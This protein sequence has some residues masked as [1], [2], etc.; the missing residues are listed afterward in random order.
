MNAVPRRVAATV[1]LGTLLNPL[2]SSM[3]VVGLVTLQREFHV[4]V[5]ASSWLI[6]GFYLAACVGQPLMGRMADRFGPR[7]VFCAGLALVFV[8]GVAALLAP[9]FGWLVGCRVAQAVGT[10]AA[11]PSGLA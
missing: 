8:A 3:I 10:S 6:S 7:R 9:G 1:A 2:N 5:A 4:G 11:F